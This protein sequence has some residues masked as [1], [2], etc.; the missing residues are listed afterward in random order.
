LN[1]GWGKFS[2]IP[3]GFGTDIVVAFY[4]QISGLEINFLSPATGN[5]SALS[6]KEK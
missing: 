5:P 2:I 6:G 4:R 1:R 3:A